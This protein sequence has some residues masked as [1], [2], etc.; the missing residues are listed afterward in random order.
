MSDLLPRGAEREPRAAYDVLRVCRCDVVRSH[1]DNRGGPTPLGGERDAESPLNP[2]HHAPG[3]NVNH[4]A[5]RDERTDGER[6]RIEE[7][8][9][10]AAVGAQHNVVGRSRVG[11]RSPPALGVPHR[12]AAGGPRPGESEGAAGAGGDLAHRHGLASPSRPRAEP[13]VD[14]LDAAAVAPQGE[15]SPVRAA[16]HGRDELQVGIEGGPKVRPGA[17]R[18]HALARQQVT[19]VETIGL[20]RERHAG[21]EYGGLGYRREHLD[22]LPTRLEVVDPYA[23][24]SQHGHRILDGPLLLPRRRDVSPVGAE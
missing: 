19:D 5:L 3:L 21:A 2:R 10:Q 16:G 24:V 6:I 7:G 17:E 8:T 11:Q 22:D 12:R 13:E 4:A 23:R 14:D 15:A 20:D 9:H 1:G 18:A